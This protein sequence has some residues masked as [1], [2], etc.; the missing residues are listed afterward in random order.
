MTAFTACWQPEESFATLS[1]KH[2][3]ASLPPLGTPEQ[4][5]MKSERQF[6]RIALCCSGVGSCAPAKCAAE[7]EPAISSAT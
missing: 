2:C 7:S 6:E 3:I 5:A 1:F 4:F